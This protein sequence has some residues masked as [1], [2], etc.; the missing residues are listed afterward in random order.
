M[1]AIYFY[2]AGSLVCFAIAWVGYLRHGFGYSMH[3][4]QRLYEVGEIVLMSFTLA[5]MW[6]I[7]GVYQLAI[8]LQVFDPASGCSLFDRL[9]EI[10]A[11][12]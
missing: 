3:W 6:P 4:R 12:K 7:L 5:I 9:A 11:E 2:A 1:S 10:K 8:N